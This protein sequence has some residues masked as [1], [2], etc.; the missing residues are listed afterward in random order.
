[1]HAWLCAKEQI[2][3]ER[4]QLVGTFV[5]GPLPASDPS[6]HAWLTDS[7]K[8]LDGMKAVEDGQTAMGLE[9]ANRVV[10]VEDTGVALAH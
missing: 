7:L 5:G 8:A 3:A 10:S 1:M 9:R 2:G 6:A 4:A